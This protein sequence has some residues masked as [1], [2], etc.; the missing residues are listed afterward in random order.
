MNTTVRFGDFCV[1]QT[2]VVISAGVIGGDYVYLAPGVK[3]ADNVKIADH[4]TIG[5]NAVV[6]KDITES[7]TAWAGVPA[8]KISEKGFDENE[9]YRH[10]NRINEKC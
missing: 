5:M 9:K 8:R 10:E 1:I 3:I 4:V 7:G 6:T 2:G